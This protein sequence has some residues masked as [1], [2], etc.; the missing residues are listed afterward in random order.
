VLLFDSFVAFLSVA[1]II[2]NRHNRH[3]A[4]IR[5]ESDVHIYRGLQA[6]FCW[7][8][9]FSFAED[10]DPGFRFEIKDIR[11]GIAIG[12]S[13]EN[14]IRSGCYGRDAGKEEKEID[15]LV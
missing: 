7:R 9:V 1:L 8:R 5:A 13:S 12:D 11:S 4:P 15:S 6:G 10:Y 2:G 14:D 3:D